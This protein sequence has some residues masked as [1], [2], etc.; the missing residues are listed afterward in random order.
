MKN[1]I[2][3]VEPLTWEEY[4][5]NFLMLKK[6]EGR[7]PRTLRDY[8]YWVTDF[9]NRYPSSLD[10]WQALKQGVMEYFSRDLAPATFNGVRVRLKAF[11]SYLVEEGAI[12]Q[13]PIDF[14]KRKDAQ[15]PKNVPK[16]VL[17]KLLELPDRSTF[18]GLRDYCLIL[19]ALDTGIRPGEALKLLPQHV[20]LDSLE[21][22]IP[23]EVSKTRVSRTIPMSTALLPELYK[24][25]KARPSWWGEDVPIFCSCEGTAMLE[26]SWS[27]RLKEYSKKLGYNITPYSLRHTFALLYLRNGG[28][29]FALQRTMGH[30]DLNMTR[31]YLALTQ[32]D[33]KKELERATPINSLVRKKKVRL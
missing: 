7:A 20:S 6:V 12:P 11:F 2:K 5:K 30:A 16:E 25:L 31:R 24:L 18:V 27:H 26:T 4:L 15:K 22:T 3:L 21:I 17:S 23:R 9:F 29:V 1:I 14:P 32:D 8:T 33:L 10:N 19:L 28:N 13:N